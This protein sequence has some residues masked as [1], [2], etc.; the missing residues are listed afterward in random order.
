MTVN[1]GDQVVDLVNNLGVGTVLNLYWNFHDNPSGELLATCSFSSLETD[2][3]EPTIC[4]RSL[5]EISKDLSL[6][7][8]M[9]R[10]IPILT[11]PADRAQF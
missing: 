5:N 7:S 10:R 1:A 9:D 6:V 3:G 8:A 4:D 11:L 2:E